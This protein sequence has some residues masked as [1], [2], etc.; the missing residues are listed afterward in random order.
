[1]LILCVCLCIPSLSIAGDCQPEDCEDI[2]IFDLLNREQMTMEEA[3]GMLLFLKTNKEC[4]RGLLSE[5][6]YKRFFWDVS[7]L[8]WFLEKERQSEIQRLISLN[9][10]DTRFYGNMREAHL[11]HQVV[12]DLDINSE[13]MPRTMGWRSC[14][15]NITISAWGLMQRDDPEVTHEDAAE[16]HRVWDD[17]NGDLDIRSWLGYQLS[18]EEFYGADYRLGTVYIGLEDFSFMDSGTFYKGVR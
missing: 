8:E 12:L 14:G 2:M 9:P 7:N 15:P 6:E 5:S 13:L 10:D 18:L 11:T 3:W 17:E 4:C 16:V 1:M